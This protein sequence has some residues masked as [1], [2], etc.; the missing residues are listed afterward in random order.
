MLYIGTTLSIPPTLSVAE[1][2]GIAQV[3]VTVSTAIDIDISV[4]ATEGK[5]RQG[6]IH[7]EIPVKFCTKS[8]SG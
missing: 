6:Q 5:V 1:G 8:I 3:C 7:Q 4:S 2:D